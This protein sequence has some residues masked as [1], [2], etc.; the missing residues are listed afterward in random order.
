MNQSLTLSEIKQRWNEVLDVVE[1]ENRVAWLAYFDARLVSFDNN[2]LRL[3]FVDAEKLSGVHDYSAVRK[4]SHRDVL[5]QACAEIF[6]QQ[7]DIIEE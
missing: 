2:Q 3:S 6:E 5:Q 7:I 4:Q 1:R